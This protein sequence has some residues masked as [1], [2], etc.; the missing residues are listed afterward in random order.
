MA[1]T[2]R[3][4]PLRVFEKKAT[5]ALG[6]TFS[7]LSCSLL[8]C[9]AELHSK[10]IVSCKRK[11]LLEICSPEE[12]SSSCQNGRTLVSTLKQPRNSTPHPQKFLPVLGSLKY[13]LS[14]HPLETMSRNL[15]SNA[16]SPSHRQ[17]RQDGAI[18]PA[19]TRIISTNS[20]RRL[21][22]SS[23]DIVH[24]GV[25]TIQQMGNLRLQ[26]SHFGTPP[27]DSTNLPSRSKGEG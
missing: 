25:A 7:C 23:T 14:R 2:A 19:N 26:F 6:T 4:R 15:K 1:S 22:W 3:P 16:N 11:R 12:R 21:P 27:Q 13:L 5:R 10:R 17:P 18:R 8:G 24:V 9:G 20:R